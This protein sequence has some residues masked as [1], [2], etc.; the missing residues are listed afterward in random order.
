LIIINVVAFLLTIVTQPTSIGANLAK[1]FIN[2]LIL[3]GIMYLIG[4]S[5]ENAGKHIE[6]DVPLYGKYVAVSK[7]ETLPELEDHKPLL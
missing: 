6:F 3:Y 2:V 1:T 7:K 5:A 4:R